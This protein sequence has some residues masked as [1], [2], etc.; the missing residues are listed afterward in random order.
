M[1]AVVQ[2]LKL[3]ILHNVFFHQ[4]PEYAI[5]YAS[6]RGQKCS[7][8]VNVA[9]RV[10]LVLGIEYCRTTLTFAAVYSVHAV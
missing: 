6:C 7:S 10:W 3:M 8:I 9:L 2:V 4:N 1:M 5:P